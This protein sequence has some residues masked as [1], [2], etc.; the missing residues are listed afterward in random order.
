MKFIWSKFGQSEVVFDGY[1]AGPST[2]DHVH[3]LRNV[4][5]RG[6]F[7]FT[8]NGITKKRLINKPSPQ[9]EKNKKRFIKLL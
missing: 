3:C 7:E 5:K 4:K 8:L 6:I 1:K 9:M 2:E